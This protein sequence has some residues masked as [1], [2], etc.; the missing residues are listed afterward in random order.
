MNIINAALQILP[1]GN[2]KSEVYSY[3]DKAIA[4]IK[5]SGL[6]YEVCPFETVIEGS[7]DEVMAVIKKAQDA[8]LDAGAKDLLAY[9][10]I[11]RSNNKDVSIEDKMGK[12]R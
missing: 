6:K 2:D 1:S 12:Y 8:C 7:Y 4:I 9:V 10:K 11:Q 5:N 3:V